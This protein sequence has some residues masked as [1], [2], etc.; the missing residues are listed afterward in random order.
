MGAK[1]FGIELCWTKLFTVAKGT[2]FKSDCGGG[3]EDI[4]IN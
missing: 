4:K 1:I 3:F 2:D